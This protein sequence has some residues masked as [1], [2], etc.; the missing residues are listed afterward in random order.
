MLAALLRSAGADVHDPGLVRDESAAV[1][2]ALTGADA[3]LILTIGG[4]SVGDHDL[5]VP[6]LRSLGAEIDFW[7]VAIRPGK[8]LLAGMLDG[9]RVLGL[10]GN[11]IS[12]FVTALLFAVPLIA[13]L[14]GREQALPLETLALAVPLPGND[15]RRDHLRAR[16]TPDGAEPFAAQDSA[17]LSRLAAADLL[18]IREAHAPPATVGDPVSCIALDRFHSVF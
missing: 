6:V 7:K 3:D 5:V 13:R 14:G 2:A 10:P 4:A 12:A 16:R 11:P 18:I 9:R 8:P 17:M 1:A 15:G